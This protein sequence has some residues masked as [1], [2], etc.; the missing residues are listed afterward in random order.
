MDALPVLLPGNRKARI[1]PRPFGLWPRLPLR[2]LSSPVC[3]L[4]SSWPLCMSQALPTLAFYRTV[5]CLRASLPRL[6]S[7]PTQHFP[8]APVGGG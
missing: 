5:L 2:L 6:C 1:F 4:P 7:A 3:L 8:E